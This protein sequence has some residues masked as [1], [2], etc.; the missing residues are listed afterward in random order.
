VRVI[1]FWTKIIAGVG[2][3]YVL[4]FS[5]L[6]YLF[7]N[8][9][10]NL[11]T[12]TSLFLV[13]PIFGLVIFSFPIYYPVHNLL[14]FFGIELLNKFWPSSATELV[15]T[16]FVFTMLFALL[17]A[18]MGVIINLLQKIFRKPKYSGDLGR[19]EVKN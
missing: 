18:I 10:P 13:L 9:I 12:T 1:I 8:A 19:G 17:G 15:T 11:N 7:Y 6:G 4:T 14:G 16:I 2:F 3:L 5:S